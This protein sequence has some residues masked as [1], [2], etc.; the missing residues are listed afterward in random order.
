M[1][2]RSICGLCVNLAN[3]EAD[4]KA[5]LLS[6]HV[7][8][9]HLCDVCNKVLYNSSDI[10][11][12]IS[13]H[14][15]DKYPACTIYERSFPTSLNRMD[16]LLQHGNEIKQELI[17]TTSATAQNG[18]DVPA[19]LFMC[20]M[21]NHALA[22][23][24][25]LKFHILSHE[26]KQSEICSEV[27]DNRGDDEYYLHVETPGIGA[28]LEVTPAK[29]NTITVAATK[30]KQTKTKRKKTKTAT[31]ECEF[32]KRLFTSKKW[33]QRHESRHK[34]RTEGS[35]GDEFTLE[36]LVSDDA[37]A[38]KLKEALATIKTE[39]VHQ[40]IKQL[41]DSN[42]QVNNSNEQVNDS[43]K[44]VHNSNDIDDKYH[45]DDSKFDSSAEQPR[46]R[47]KFA[48][49]R[50]KS[51]TSIDAKSK[52]NRKQLLLKT[53]PHQCSL[54][55]RYFSTDKSLVLHLIDHKEGASLDC[56]YCE[57]TYVDKH[58]LKR[59]TERHLIRHKCSDCPE[60]F[61]SLFLLDKHMLSHATNGLGSYKCDT[62]TKV[63]CLQAMLRMHKK[64][65]KREQNQYVCE[66]CGNI[67][68]NIN[69]WRAH[70]R[71]HTG[72]AFQCDVCDKKFLQKETLTAHRAVHTGVK[73]FVCETCGKAYYLQASLASHIERH[74]SSKTRDHPCHVC[75][76]SFFTSHD[77]ATHALSHQ[78]VRK[79]ACEICGKTFKVKGQL[80]SHYI[81]H[82]QDKP[83][84]CDLC[85]YAA[86]IPLLLRRH[87][88]GHRTD[89]SHHCQH[90]E[91]RFKRRSGLLRHVRHV[92]TKPDYKPHKCDTCGKGFRTRYHLQRHDLF[93]KGEQPFGC[94]VCG[95]RY[96]QKYHMLQH[97]SS[98]FKQQEYH[99]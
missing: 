21:C 26:K 12:H 9:V 87:L 55:H 37:V 14:V 42:K 10:D 3:C 41:V 64:H 79:F 11:T 8:S 30:P 40:S 17:E 82:K 5:H 45:S 13:S 43:T 75:D 31:F 60:E 24:V 23:E 32:C 93:H 99:A 16:H 86:T 15:V 22:N 47:T 95:K 48:L 81:V 33:L 72:E 98:H 50:R 83:Y 28:D 1:K 54:C 90:C 20:D 25:E 77:L 73:P 63:F 65:H 38:K 71:R 76:K 2:D 80:T 39:K 94:D 66:F 29:Q 7:H 27:Q 91:M 61:R 84:K 53:T 49:K 58:L 6:H 74:H 92:H 85:D 62:C 59:H 68:C 46:S 70:K 89:K 57:K 67:S 19:E 4:L 56:D 52:A 97:R 69:R 44:N 96:R 34:Q 78:N 51:A 36:P 35:G 18:A 88:E